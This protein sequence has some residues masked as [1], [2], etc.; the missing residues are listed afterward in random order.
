MNPN[1]GLWEKGEFTR[2]AE[3]MRPSGEALVRKLG[4][5]KGLH[6]SP[7]TSRGALQVGKVCAKA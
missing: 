2:I 1:K 5:T 3:S 4:I 7:H 6:G